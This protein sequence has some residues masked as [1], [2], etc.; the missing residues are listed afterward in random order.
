MLEASIS[1]DVNWLS[2][3]P[4]FGTSV[5]SIYS[6][7]GFG[8]SVYFD[9]SEFFDGVYEAVI[10]ITDPEAY[11]SPFEISVSMVIGERSPVYRFWS[12]QN[13]SHF[14]TTSGYEK[15]SISTNYPSEVWKYERIAWYA[16]LAGDAPSNSRPIYRFWSERHGSHFYTISEEEKNYIRATYPKDIWEYEWDV[17]YAYILHF[18]SS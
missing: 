1:S 2:F 4:E 17:F 10:T 6:C 8:S 3:N 15:D 16:H 9:I 14:Y 5:G 13:R 11:N 12:D 18:A 7:S